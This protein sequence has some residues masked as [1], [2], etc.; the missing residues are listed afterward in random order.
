MDFIEELEKYFEETPREKVLEDWE[1]T[2]D[3]DNVG[4][5]CEEFLK[6]ANENIKKNIEE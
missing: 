4:I 2:K 3:W 5:T 1:N 6:I